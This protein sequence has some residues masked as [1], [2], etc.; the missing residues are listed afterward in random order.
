MVYERADSD[1]NGA[2]GFMT[3]RLRRGFIAVAAAFMLVC[4]AIAGGAQSLQRLTVTRFT[5]ASDTATPTL[6]V[7]F[8][9]LITVHV[10][11]R[12]DEL[13]TLDLPVF[14]SLELLGDERRLTSNTSGTIYRETITVVAHH[15][16]TIH[17]APATLDA[18]DARDGK[19]KRYFSNALTLVVQGGALKPL[20]DFGSGLTA[21]VLSL[22]RV[23]MVLVGI[24]CAVAIVVLL[25]RRRA[26]QQ[27][28]AQPTPTAEPAEPARDARDELRDVM[29]VLR[30]SPTRANAMRAR[31]WARSI[32]GATDA[33]TL[34]DVLAQ[35]PSADPLV[36][37]VLRTLERAAFTYDADLQV[38]I[39]DAVDALEHATL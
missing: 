37:R 12:I 13:D 17:I 38:A 30:A 8:H 23:L 19:P 10:D 2:S 26:T 18:I 4:V 31:S 20:Q 11:Q 1:C 6:E 7:P 25:F 29:L 36:A 14:T 28:P 39:A 33:Q 3:P 24:A 5:L 27:P 34:A 9:L 21:V 16:G 32:V 22:L 15:T 35:P